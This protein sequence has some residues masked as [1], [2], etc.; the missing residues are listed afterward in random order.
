MWGEGILLLLK[1][2]GLP[3]SIMAS[4][5]FPGV[6][7]WKEVSVPEELHWT[8]GPNIAS[9]KPQRKC[10]LQQNCQSL[11]LKPRVLNILIYIFWYHFLKVWQVLAL[12]VK[13]SQ[14]PS[15]WSPQS[16]S[17]R[18]PPFFYKY[19]TTY[20]AT[21]THGTFSGSFCNRWTACN[22]QQCKQTSRQL[23][24]QRL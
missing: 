10:L 14:I 4:P 11:A 20:K 22:I 12:H 6:W 18:K 2:H 16:L 17:R 3:S 21:N 8:E 13:T 15:H 1:A 7:G 19:P 9:Q 23:Y 24:I 5:D